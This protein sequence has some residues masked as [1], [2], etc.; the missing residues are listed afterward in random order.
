MRQ[1]RNRKIV[2]I[3]MRICFDNYVQTRFLPTFHKHREM[4]NVNVCIFLTKRKRVHRLKIFE[5]RKSV[6]FKRI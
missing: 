2:V 6:G 5:E 3:I 1:G 4:Y